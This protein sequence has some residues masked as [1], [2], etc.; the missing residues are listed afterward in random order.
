MIEQFI[1]DG[2]KA[3]IKSDTDEDIKRELA[4]DSIVPEW[5]KILKNEQKLRERK[6]KVKVNFT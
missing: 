1:L 2:W 4:K 5:R 3:G 6:A